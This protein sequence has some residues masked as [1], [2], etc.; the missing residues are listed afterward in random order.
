M[1]RF[2][3][4]VT[5]IL[6]SISLVACSSASGKTENITAPIEKDRNLS[7]VVTTDVHYFAPSLTDNGKAFEKY[8]AAGDGKQEAD[9][10]AVA[11]AFLADVEAKKTDVRIV[12]GALTNNGEKSRDEDLAKKL[13]QVE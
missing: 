12:S 2:F 6:L 11:D 5:P 9:S 3:K 1:I 4:I 13:T 10:D 8:V 7:M